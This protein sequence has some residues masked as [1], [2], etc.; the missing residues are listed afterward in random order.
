MFMTKVLQ[1][2]DNE[3]TLHFLKGVLAMILLLL[4]ATAAMTTPDITVR[5]EQPRGE[6]GYPAGTLAFDAI[7]A[8]DYSGAEQMLL[9]ADVA[10][11]QDAAWLINYGRVLGQTGR[12][13]EAE[14]VLK[15]AMRLE[16]GELILADG[17]TMRSRDAAAAALTR[18]RAGRLS[19][20]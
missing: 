12:P 3:V 10:Q 7:M 16:D 2:G 5:A 13:F 14:R 6:V 15:Q 20:R 1:F 19:S 9:R 17:R 8:G 4:A 11:R 18:L